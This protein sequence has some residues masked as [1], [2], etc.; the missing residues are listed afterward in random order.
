MALGTM[1]NPKTGI[2]YTPAEMQAMG[3]Y[4]PAL[5]DVVE[6][7]MLGT[8]APRFAPPK[9]LD[10]GGGTGGTGGVTYIPPADTYTPQ[11]IGGGRTVDDIYN[12][13]A[14]P[15]PTA[16]PNPAIVNPYTRGIIEQGI[17]SGA[18][19]AIDFE[20]ETA[21]RIEALKNT[22]T[23]ATQA[24]MSRGLEEAQRLYQR[25]GK[26]GSS[27]ALY[28][29]GGMVRTTEGYALQAGSQIAQGMGDIY[30][31][32]GQE[33]TAERGNI[34]G[35][36]NTEMGA[37]INTQ[38]S[39][40]IADLNARTDRAIAQ[41]NADTTLT[42]YEKQIQIAQINRQTSI[43]VANITGEYDIK[44]IEKSGEIQKELQTAEFTFNTDPTTGRPG[45]L[46]AQ[47]ITKLTNINPDTGKP[48]TSEEFYAGLSHDM[49]KFNISNAN[50]MQ[51]FKETMA[52]AEKELGLTLKQ[53]KELAMK[54]LD[55]N[56]RQFDIT[57]ATDIK[58]FKENMAWAREELGMTLAQEK[59][60]TDRAINTQIDQ[61]NIK[62]AQDFN[63]SIK[64]INQSADQ[65]NATIAETIDYNKKTLAIAQQSADD[66]SVKNAADIALAVLDNDSIFA[67]LSE[68]EGDP[69]A[70]FIGKIF[71]DAMNMTP[72]E[73]DKWLADYEKGGTMEYAGPGTGKGV[74]INGARLPG[75][76]NGMKFQIRDTNGKWW[77][78]TPTVYADY[79]KRG[80]L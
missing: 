33:R 65:F 11:T 43:D 34:Y 20:A 41:V 72:E 69:L 30:A 63:L 79:K 10:T 15:A 2:R 42:G 53:Q 38:S 13:S 4:D 17:Q 70:D 75:I 35:L 80:N 23:P 25:S 44:G 76:E 6:T 73:T 68:M 62:T 50:D 21:K 18:L 22:V 39:E 67:M 32:V 78:V 36:A 45:W 57:S 19:P 16:T 24:L 14:A 37:T 66:A 29:P 56:I 47:D 46:S 9:R 7:P 8:E 61:F 60:L 31:Q 49:T 28:G 77:N 48:W 74:I 71:G 64:Q 3:A 59:E 40:R 55:E 58:Q 5:L 1:I 12:R 52:W 51:K 54:A 26:L 27:A